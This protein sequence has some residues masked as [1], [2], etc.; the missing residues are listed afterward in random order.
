M[1]TGYR[2]QKNDRL[3]KRKEFL[4]I[5]QDGK[6]VGDRYFTIRYLLNDVNR[7]R[8]GIIVTKKIGNA[9][10][11]NRIKRVVRTFFR[12]HRHRLDMP[13]DVVVI[14]RGPAAGMKTKTAHTLLEALF[15]QLSGKTI[16]ADHRDRAGKN[17]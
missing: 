17:Q 11:R 10:T 15:N 7:P 14:A 6:Q 4:Q 3:L 12:H 1:L 5:S 9:V 8:L 13:W 2:F 16:P